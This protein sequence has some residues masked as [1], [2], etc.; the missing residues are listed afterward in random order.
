MAIRNDDRR[1]KR[2]LLLAAF[3]AGKA[4]ASL[5]LLRR[6]AIGRA[7]LPAL[8]LDPGPALLDDEVLALQRLFDQ[9][10]RLVAHR[11]F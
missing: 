6:N 7:A 5:A 1:L 8:G 11:L 4:H 3:L 9:T 10:L 2:R